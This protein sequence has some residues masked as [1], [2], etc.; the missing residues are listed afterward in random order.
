MREGERGER[1]GDISAACSRS[2]SGEQVQAVAPKI[3]VPA[4]ALTATGETT[5]GRKQ[6]EEKQAGRK[7]SKLGNCN[8]RE[9]R[10]RLR[11]RLQPWQVGRAYSHKYWNTVFGSE[12]PSIRKTQ[13]H[14][15]RFRGE[16]Q[17]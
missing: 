7:S 3:Q 11:R 6:H 12:A 10:P 13:T 8:I 1:T 5:Q 16:P 15:S 14:S 9:M 4:K 17:R 2:R